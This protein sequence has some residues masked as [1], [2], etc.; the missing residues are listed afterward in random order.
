[1][2]KL[3][4][5]KESCIGCGACMALVE[6]VFEMGDDGLAQTSDNNNLDK[7]DKELKNEVIEAVEGCPTSAIV[8]EEQKTE[9]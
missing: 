7:M 3:K 8:I 6:E 2:E 9:F 5:N 4:V 1:M